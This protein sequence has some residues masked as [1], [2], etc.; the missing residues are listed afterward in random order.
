MW[1][2]SRLKKNVVPC[3]QIK[4]VLSPYLDDELDPETRERVQTHLRECPAC[5]EE[6][7]FQQVFW[8]S[9]KQLPEVEPPPAF[10]A[11]VMAR[12]GEKRLK[13]RWGFTGFPMLNFRPSLVY[14]SVFFL[15]LFLGILIGTNLV[16]NPLPV[17]NQT[18]EPEVNMTQLLSESMDL[19]LQNVRETS[20]E[21]LATA[22][23][24]PGNPPAK[25]SNFN[26]EGE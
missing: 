8:T 18:P 9:V 22:H 10:N 7:N 26:A 16:K 6:I 19:Q 11:F 23:T 4:H 5:N 1:T 2:Q 13:N 17:F 14:S 20:M 3:D 12:L 25:P 15:F 24:S 21:L